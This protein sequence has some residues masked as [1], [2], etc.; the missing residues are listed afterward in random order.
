MMTPWLPVARP[1]TGQAVRRVARPGLAAAVAALWLGLLW[2]A[3]I[4]PLNAPDEPAY[5]QTVAQVRRERALPEIHFD[6]S[7]NPAGEV[8]GAPG[9]T[10]VRAYT[11]QAGFTDAIRSSPTRRCSRPSISCSPRW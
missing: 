7:R 3:A 5:L 9:D 8:I 10:A 11:A 2:A 1:A 6:F 4:K